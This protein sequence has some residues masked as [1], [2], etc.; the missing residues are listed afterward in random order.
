MSDPSS[1]WY[2][3]TRKC[4]FCDS[5]D[6]WRYAEQVSNDDNFCWDCQKVYP[7]EPEGTHEVG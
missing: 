6:F 1:E 5:V 2:P 4:P 3:A 7:V